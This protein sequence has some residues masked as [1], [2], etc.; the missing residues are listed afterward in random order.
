[1]DALSARLCTVSTRQVALF[2]FGPVRINAAL[3]NVFDKTYYYTDNLSRYS[4]G[5]E[6]RVLPGEPRTFS[7]RLSYNFG[8][9]RR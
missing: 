9:A 6:D 8:G 3:T 2:D 7:V 5:T 1:L 4:I